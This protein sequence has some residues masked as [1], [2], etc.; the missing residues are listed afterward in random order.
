MRFKRFAALLLTLL[1]VTAPPGCRAEEAE[2]TKPGEILVVYPEEMDRKSSPDNLSALA[3]ILFSLR[4][5]ADYTWRR[6][7]RMA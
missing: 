1:A 7:R 5:T 6:K 4:Y 2:E 3:E